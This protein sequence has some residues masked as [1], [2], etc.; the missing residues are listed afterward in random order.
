MVRLVSRETLAIRSA[1]HGP[2]G[3]AAWKGSSAVSVSTIGFHMLGCAGG[4]LVAV[5]GGVAGS[6]VISIAGAV[7]SAVASAST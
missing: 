4:A 2:V 6:P 5:L 3:G 7:V 1:T